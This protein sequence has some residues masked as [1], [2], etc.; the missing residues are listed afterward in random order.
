MDKGQSLARALIPRHARGIK[1][2]WPS[3]VCPDSNDCTDMTRTLDNSA[4]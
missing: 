2:H 1:V 3:M 4:E